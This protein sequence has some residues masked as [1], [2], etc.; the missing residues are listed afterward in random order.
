MS[1]FF[2]NAKTDNPI[3]LN[4]EY[5]VLLGN[6]D[7]VDENNNLR[8]TED[9]EKVLAKKIYRDNGSQKL[10]I[11]CDSYNRPLNPENQITSNK[12]VSSY[13]SGYKFINVSQKAFEYYIKFLQTK[14][15]SWLLNTERELM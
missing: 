12:T 13:K 2:T 14:N 11:K 15:Q 3:K 5:Y 1:D 8:S 10:M 4:N 9:C 6:E 7:F